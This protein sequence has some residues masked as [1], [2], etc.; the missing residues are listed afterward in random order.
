MTTAK[1]TYNLASISLKER[2]SWIMLL[3]LVLLNKK[4]VIQNVDGIQRATALTICSE[5]V[6]FLFWNVTEVKYMC[7]FHVMLIQL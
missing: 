2:S 4:D 3:F 1:V 5:T 7:Y 6:V